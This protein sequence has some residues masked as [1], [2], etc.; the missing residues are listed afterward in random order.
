MSAALPPNDPEAERAV[1]SAMLLKPSLVSEWPAW[2]RVEDFFDGRIR[3]VVEAIRAVDA[4]GAV[5]DPTTVSSELRSAGKLNGIGGVP[6]VAELVD[7]TPA[8]AHVWEHARI[9][10]SKGRIRRV[11]ALALEIAA[12][13]MGEVADVREWL[14]SV[15]AR[16]FTATQTTDTDDTISTFLESVPREHA[17]IVERSRSEDKLDGIPTGFSD[18]DRKLGGLKPGNKYTIAARPGM[19][20]S[21]LAQSIAVNVAAAGHAV[22][23]ISLE[24][25]TSQIVQRAIAQHAGIDTQRIASGEIRS[26]EWQ[27]VTLAVDDLSAL[28][29]AVD[30][31]GTHTVASARSAVRRC[32]AKLQREHSGKKLG[33]VVFD[34]V[35]IMTATAKGR[36]RDN[37]VSELSAGTRLLAKEFDCVVLELSQLNREVEKRGDKRPVL[38]DLRDSGSLEQDS[39][40][41][42]MLYRDDYYNE[43]SQDRGLCDVLIR[44]LRQGGS[45][46]MVRLK[47]TPETTRFATL[48]SE[49]DEMGDWADDYGGA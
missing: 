6:F 35:Q 13:A 23:F 27:R 19:G 11:R 1:V 18:L 33:L 20:K 34:Y 7:A 41:I 22:A 43:N 26:D 37:D 14:Q 29:L 45:C 46:G 25:P 47:F 32:L 15:E 4:S 39:F 49:Y 24:M 8:V 38:S 3:L 40:G 9:V 5:V 28:P 12:E 42:L 31:A 21:A 16:L 48:A 30:Q 44:K 2:L 17:A 10:A 36:S